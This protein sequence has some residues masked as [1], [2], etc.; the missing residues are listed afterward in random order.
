[1]DMT[2]STDDQF[3]AIEIRIRESTTRVWSRQVG[4]FQPAETWMPS[5]NIYRLDA[6]LVICVD[7]AGVE[8]TSL[9][10]H[11]APGMLIVRG[12]RYSPDPREESQR[13]MRIESM[14]IDHGPFCRNIPLREPIDLHH[15]ET[16]YHKGLLW[17]R[18]P[19]LAPPRK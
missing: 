12:V 9:D 13:R 6:T 10:V 16:E 19:M 2:S 8:P 7:L 3:E 4:Q 15:A 17:I 11:V 18:L 14:E 5:V 1:M